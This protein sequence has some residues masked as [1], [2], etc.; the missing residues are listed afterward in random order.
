MYLIA[1]ATKNYWWPF[2]IIKK[3]NLKFGDGC[4]LKK[5]TS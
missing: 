4:L 1:K 2:L 5:K 3:D